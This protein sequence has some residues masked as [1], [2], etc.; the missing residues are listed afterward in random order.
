M[1]DDDSLS[2]LLFPFLMPASISMSTFS[3]LIRGIAD[4]PEGELGSPHTHLFYPSTD[5][6]EHRELY[7]FMVRH[8]ACKPLIKPD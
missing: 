8:D 3:Y 7:G 6:G 1:I 4:S 2:A 5:S